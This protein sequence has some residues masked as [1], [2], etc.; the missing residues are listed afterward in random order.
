MQ[1]FMYYLYETNVGLSL[2]KIKDDKVK[3]LKSVMFGNP[4][5]AADHQSLE[6]V[7]APLKQ[8]IDE[9]LN[10]QS[11]KDKKVKLQLSCKEVAEF[12]RSEFDLK[13]TSTKSIA[14][15]DSINKQISRYLAN[16][17]M[18][19]SRTDAA[20]TNLFSSS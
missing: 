12:I 2:Y 10:L 6:K 20:Q 16:N 14:E 18:E 19:P 5:E 4:E 3:L 8:I 7:T 15:R 17:G 9:V 1:G 13:T 11:K